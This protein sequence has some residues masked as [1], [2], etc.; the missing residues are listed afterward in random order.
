MQNHGDCTAVNSAVQCYDA[1]LSFS[2][3]FLAGSWRRVEELPGV[4]KYA[5]DAHA[6]FCLGR[7]REVTPDD[8]ALKAYHEWLSSLA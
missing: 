2:R 1:L 4:G 6:I 5:A 3:A 8:H 7:W